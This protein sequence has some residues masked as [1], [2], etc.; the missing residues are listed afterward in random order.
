MSN[1]SVFFKIFFVF[2]LIILIGFGIYFWQR[3]INVPSTNIK[4]GNAIL[5][6]EIAD[7]PFERTNGLSFREKIGENEGM[8]FI[9]EDSQ[10]R[11]FWMKNMKFSVDIIWI[12]ENLKVVGIQENVPPESYPDTF[13]S[14][15]PVKYVIEVNA[16]W[17]K[18]NKIKTGDKI[19]FLEKKYQ[20]RYGK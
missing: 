4:I 15:K 8:I 17:T 20:E 2:I 13:E 12:D 19:L 3:K 9:F 7:T 6:V 10:Y 5:S 16:G 18:K 1:R 14:P 11:K